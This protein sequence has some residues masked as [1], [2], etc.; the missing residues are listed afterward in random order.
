MTEIGGSPLTMVQIRRLSWLALPFFA[1]A[2]GGSEGNGEGNDSTG[3][4]PMD[5]GSPPDMGD[6]VVDMGNPVDLPTV[7]ATPDEIDFQFVLVNTSVSQNITIENTSDV[8]AIIQFDDFV[9]VDLCRFMTRDSFCIDVED[10]PDGF[11]LDAGD[12]LQVQVQGTAQLAGVDETGSFNVVFCDEPNGCTAQVELAYSSVSSAFD[13]A[14]GDDPT[15]DIGEVNLDST[16]VRNLDC[17]N[18]IA[19]PVAL[20]EPRFE[21]AS[22]DA[23]SI[24]G[25]AVVGDV[26]PGQTVVL[27]IQ[28]EGDVQEEKTGGLILQY[29]VF[30]MTVSNRIE[31]TAEVGGADLQLSREAVDFRQCSTLATCSET[32]VITNAGVD[33]LVFEPFIESSNNATLMLE[34]NTA[35]D[36]QPGQSVNFVLSLDAA[37]AGNFAGA[38]RFESNDPDRL[39]FELPFSGEGVST[40]TCNNFA[41]DR[42]SIDFGLVPSFRSAQQYVVLDNRSG[43]PCLVR[44]IGLTPDTSDTFSLP[45]DDNLLLIP[46]NNRATLPIEFTPPGQSTSSGTVEFQI[47]SPFDPFRSVDIAG[48]GTEALLLS[49]A[50]TEIDLGTVP[51]DCVS[52]S[53]RASLN[54][55]GVS[56]INVNAFSTLEGEVSFSIPNDPSGPVSPLFERPFQIDFTPMGDGPVAD[57]IQVQ[58]SAGTQFISLFAEQAPSRTERFTQPVSNQADVLIVVDNNNTNSPNGTTVSTLAPDWFDRAAANGIDLRMAVTSTDLTQEDGLFAP[59]DGG[60]ER[61]VDASALPSPAEVLQANVGSL[62]SGFATPRGLDALV[63]ALTPRAVTLLNPNFYRPDAMLTVVFVQDEQDQSSADA[64]E[65]L[66]FLQ[67]FKGHR[68]R[69]AFAVAAITGGDEGCNEPSK[70]ATASPRLVTMQEATAGP[71]F[72]ICIISAIQPDFFDRALG[73][74]DTFLLDSVP[75][76]DTISVSL[77][78]TTVSPSAYSYDETSNGIVFDVA[79]ANGSSIEVTY[80]SACDPIP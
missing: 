27:P 52:T 60:P 78:G 44:A 31:V 61:V 50:P 70:S 73:V 65:L 19:L 23:F 15:F 21:S 57:T 68:N 49:A 34:P 59:I 75:D 1:L 2:C 5:M 53:T 39:E 71:F 43:S 63:R 12:T 62:S 41:I 8:D 17:E 24:D 51:T 76:P 36:V 40:G 9:N 33:Q 42:N 69:E 13:C 32:V 22:N 14:T 72:S 45:I 28:V 6:P 3:N 55:L 18:I 77:D 74:R 47:S 16:I 79:P 25:M 56:A 80:G 58:T 54:N 26:D 4:V 67:Q 66:A 38:V 7:R 48:E 30:G 10:E 37:S 20:A 29:Q 46:A 11:R 35:T 64:D